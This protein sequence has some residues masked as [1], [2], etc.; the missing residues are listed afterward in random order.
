MVFEPNTLH[1][2][3]QS[4]SRGASRSEIVDD[5]VR[6]LSRRYP[7]HIDTSIPWIF[8]NAGGAMG[9]IKLL[10]CSL[11]EY[12]LLFDTPIGTEGHSGRYSAEVYDFV[13][14][15]EFWC[16]EAGDLERRMYKK[17]DAA[18][19]GVQSAKGYRVPDRLLVL[20]YA[21]GPIPRMLPFG[22]FDAIFSTVD[23]ETIVNTLWYYGRSVT[24][25]IFREIRR[26]VACEIW[27]SALRSEG[28]S[29]APASPFAKASDN[30]AE[31]GRE[32]A[33]QVG[34]A[35]V[36]AGEALCLNQHR[37]IG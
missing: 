19:L 23:R 25:N 7:R 26:S 10:Y 15:G 31:Q 27:A 3:A 36:V 2:V 16:F 35:V 5:V 9:Q 8:N 18:Y 30:L 21:R 28:H 32:A 11:S 1:D 20:E 4:A 33:S 24:K 12:V 14:D 29:S 22:L 37:S 13:L 34:R 6:E 17:G